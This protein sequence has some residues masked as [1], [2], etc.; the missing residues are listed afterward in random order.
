MSGPPLDVRMGVA[1]G[2][3]VLEAL[4]RSCRFTEEGTDLFEEVRARGPVIIAAWHGRLLPLAWRHRH[5]GYAPMI[6]QSRDGDFIAGVVAGWGYH[7]VR[8]STSRGGGAA[9]RELVR[10]SR[11]HTLVLT[12]DGPRGPRHHLQP[13]VLVAARL[14]GLPIVPLAAGADRAWWLG[15]WDRFLV[16]KPFARVHLLHGQV[17]RVPR[18]ANEDAMAAHGQRLEAELNALTA[19]ADARFLYG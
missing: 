4:L 3:R 5:R 12:P 17:H 7:P 19:R 10:R 9:L 18:D 11:A 2:R 13:G 6:S 15:G 14:T 8:G 1:V 16:P